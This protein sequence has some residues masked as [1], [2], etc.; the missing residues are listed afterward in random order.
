LT[1]DLEAQFDAVLG[2]LE[3]KV[4]QV[5]GAIRHFEA[6][7]SSAGAEAARLRAVQ[8]SYQGRADWLKGYLLRC[9]RDEAVD[10][11][12]TDIGGVS[13]CKNSRPKIEWTDPSRLPPAEF[14]VKVETVRI[15]QEAVQEAYRHGLLPDGF[16]VE[17]GEH[18]RVK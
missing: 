6:M 16:A 10:R 12:A 4:R 1:P 2:A 18:L 14:L 8:K 11:V 7:E 13:R 5:L 9:M 17:Q 3:A 15:N